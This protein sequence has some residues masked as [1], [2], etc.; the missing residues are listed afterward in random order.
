MIFYQYFLLWLIFLN[1]IRVHTSLFLFNFLFPC[2]PFS[3]SEINIFQVNVLLLL[4]CLLLN[5]Q[6][7]KKTL[8]IQTSN[9]LICIKIVMWLSCWH[10]TLMDHIYIYIYKINLRE[11]QFTW[12]L[13]F[14]I[15]QFACFDTPL[16]G[17]QGEECYSHPQVSICAGLIQACW[18]KEKSGGP[19]WA[20]GVF[21][22]TG[23]QNSL[24]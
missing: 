16:T 19:N 2:L 7:N 4:S 18:I 20:D 10:F 22:P 12:V 23:S 15:V 21:V 6:L 8:A 5:H 13:Y 9:F 14:N 17:L 11:A 1:P 3:F 24:L